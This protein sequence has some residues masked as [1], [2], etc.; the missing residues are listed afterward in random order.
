MKIIN[1]PKSVSFQ[2][3]VN[4]LY[5]NIEGIN[6]MLNNYQFNQLFHNSDIILLNE[7]MNC[8]EL[9]FKDYYTYNQTAIKPP[10][11]RQIGGLVACI[12]PNLTPELITK[13]QRC[14][15]IS[16]S[17]VKIIFCYFN[18]ETDVEDILFDQSANFVCE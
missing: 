13:N 3:N 15:Y 8:T 5:W 9:S 4:I 1:K 16:T 14:L 12:K 18:P 17:I 10:R 6:T 7:T 11:G 2:N